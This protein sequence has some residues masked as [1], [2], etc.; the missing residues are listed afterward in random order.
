MNRVLVADVLDVNNGTVNFYKY[1]SEPVLHM[2]FVPLKIVGQNPVDIQKRV[3]QVQSTL[4]GNWFGWKVGYAATRVL[5][6][7]I[8]ISLILLLRKLVRNCSIVGCRWE[9]RTTVVPRVTI[10]RRKTSRVLSICCC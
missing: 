7:L 2:V 4:A 1:N 3:A 6:V 9:T 10:L 8:L 5:V